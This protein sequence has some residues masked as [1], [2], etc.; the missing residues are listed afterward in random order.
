MSDEKKRPNANYRL[1][2]ENADPDDITFHYSRE[3]R[4]AKAPQS[5]RNLYQEE[6]KRRFGLLHAVIGTKAKAMM[7]FSIVVLCIM[8][9]LLSIL[10]VFGTTYNL[11][12]NELSVKVSGYEGTY[13]VE[14]EKSVKK[15]ILARFSG[16]YSGAVDI[17]VL[18]AKN[19]QSAQVFYH[20]IFFTLEPT[21]RYSFAVPFDTGELMLIVQT[22]KKTVN[23]SVK[24]E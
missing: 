2:K 5:V 1:S 14:L 18:P 24:P 21:E 17:A 8:F 4:L 19:V 12:G 20:K 16:A 13:I 10:G 7:F 9:F 22:E 23:I 11:E 15:N 6:P 3:H